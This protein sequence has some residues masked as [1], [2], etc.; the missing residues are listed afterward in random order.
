MRLAIIGF[1][2][3]GQGLARALVETG[4]VITAV[5]DS[6]SAA[7]NPDGLDIPEV[8]ARKEKT[9]L[10]GDTGVGSADILSSGAF[11]ILVEVS[12]T[13]ADTGEP[14]LSTI[15]SA[16]AMG[17]HVVTSN[18]GPI[19][20]AYHELKAL[21]DQKGVMIGYEATV[22]GAVPI[23]SG[24]R[25]GLAGNTVQS[26][27]GILN[28]TCNYIL[29]R[30]RDEGLTYPQALQ[31]ARD[32]GYAEA[33]PTSDV[34][35]IDAAIKLVILANT[36]LGMDVTLNDVAITGIDSITLEALSLAEAEGAT[37]RLIGE[38]LPGKN[39]VRVSPRVISLDHPLVVDGTLNA[40]S[41]CCDLAGQVTFI[42]KGAGPYPTASA[43][44]ADLNFI[45]DAYD[46]G[47]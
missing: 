14:A 20:C 2:A 30:M 38:I 12:P 7:I 36:V 45:R 21:A 39:Q 10:C 44:L 27:H 5:A 28:G 22:A 23:V 46:R 41:V 16:L 25:Q 40:I 35:G 47:A 34:K 26:L 43:I 8:L 33:D 19:A 15:R 4:F 11:D 37:I 24:L 9:G 6:R 31:E 32:L 17:K 29:T 1:G 3:V 13:N 18:K 42:G